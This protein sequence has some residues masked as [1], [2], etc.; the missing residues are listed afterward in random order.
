MRSPGVAPGEPIAGLPVGMRP[1][2]RAAPRRARVP[3]PGRPGHPYW[4]MGSQIR[5]AGDE[6]P[7]SARL[8]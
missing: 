6:V 5:R 7:G 1:V 3:P 8:R 2:A 4:G